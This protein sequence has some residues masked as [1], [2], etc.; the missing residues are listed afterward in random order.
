MQRLTEEPETRRETE[1]GEWAWMTRPIVSLSY[2]HF[3]LFWISNLI[4]AVGLMI[5]FTARGWLIVEL[6][7]SA[8]LL[9]VVEGF[10]ALAFG[11]G[12]IPMGVIA[13]RFNRRNLLVAGNVVALAMAL[14]IGLLVAVDLI[15]IWYLVVVSAIDGV[16]FAM[17][18]PSGQAM[19]AKLVPQEH[20]MNAIS[21][22]S[23]SHS[24]P[25]VAGPA[26]GGVLVGGLGVAAAYFT[27]SGALLAALLMMLGVAA[28]FGHVERGAAKGVLGD[29]REGYDYL[30]AHR[31]LL[32][33]T[34]TML[35]P[36]VLGQSY[37][38]LLPLF[39]EK[40]LHGSPEMFG[41]LS[42]CLGA[43]SVV[44]AAV[45]ATF[46]KP[47]QIGLLMFISVL[48]LGLAS[49]AYA[50]SQWPAFTGAVLFGVGAAQN[51][52]FA[53]YETALILRLPDEIRGRVIG[54]MFTITAIF[55]IGA[56][57]SGAVAD[58]IGLRPLAV[59]EGVMII[60]MALVAW[61]V[62]LRHPIVTPEQA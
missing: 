49:I 50:F 59:A 58:V 31:D 16:L 43:G 57:V 15:A 26:I 18:F 37:I 29:L 30:L 22:N 35:I 6:T 25:S 14:A 52:L 36:F 60:P 54:L 1:E 32:R 61:Q 7:D 33:L 39:V 20:V 48:G 56:I 23:A 11:L 17:R 3:R 13:D 8:L 19:T 46:G 2:P 44:G 34:A 4:V 45:V 51:T 38:L 47:R 28:S 41:V 21:L 55:P 24:L 53:S 12:S 9:G 10:W 40:E 62:A 27:T 5:Q 42:A